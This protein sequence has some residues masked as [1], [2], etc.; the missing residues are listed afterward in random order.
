MKKILITGAKGQLGLKLKEILSPNFELVLTDSA[1]MDIT[2][3]RIV[4]EVIS[5]EKPDFI[6]HAAAYT[7]VDQAEEDWELCM[8]IN[9]EG[10]KNVAKAASLYDSTLIYISTDY[11][12]DGKKTT[13]YKEEDGA[14]PLSVYGKS[15]LEGEK[16]VA[17]ISEKYYVLRAAWLFGELPTGHPGSNFV[18]TMLR[19][20][21]E[22]ESLS[23]VS[24]QIGS[25]TYTGD[26]VETINRIVGREG[27][28]YGL[29]HFSG[30]GECSWYDFAK[31]IFKQANVKIDLRP[32]K[33][34]RY[35]Q[36]AKRPPYSYLD[37]AKIKSALK[38]E[39]RSWQE[40]LKEY[41][42][43]RKIS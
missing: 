41:L 18:E 14:K 13:P 35:P 39:V 12:F 32:I 33:S 5:R 31:E 22:R 11:V 24:D 19:L 28:P 30:I 3:P 40:M 26:L 1:E 25:P 6:V 27:A 9:A 4:E 8:K 36:K 2:N 17:S 15:K 21:S 38:M 43:K 34:D 23:V 7:K 20:A 29:Y 37:K 42:E 10:T 16:Q